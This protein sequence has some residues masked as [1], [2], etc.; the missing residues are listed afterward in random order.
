LHC[1]LPGFGSL[2][3]IGRYGLNVAP[4]KVSLPLISAGPPLGGR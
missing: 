1:D 4:A 3:Y 2:R